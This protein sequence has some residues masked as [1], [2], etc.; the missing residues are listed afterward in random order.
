MLQRE[1]SSTDLDHALLTA[2]S[3]PQSRAADVFTESYAMRI[4]FESRQEKLAIEQMR[5]GSALDVFGWSTTRMFEGKYL[6]FVF[7]KT[8]RNRSALQVSMKTWEN[9]MHG[10]S[11]RSAAQAASQRWKVVQ[12][13]NDDTYFLSRDVN[14]PVTSEI[15]R[16]YYLRFRVRSLSGSGIAVVTQ[17]VHPHELD[18]ARSTEDVLMEDQTE[19]RVWGNEA[20]LWTHFVPSY[21]S[22][23]LSDGQVKEYEHCN[24][25]VVGKSSFGDERTAQLNA[26]ETVLGLLRWEN[27]NVGPLLTLTAA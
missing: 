13:V 2:F 20:C 4:I 8:F 16:M 5:L 27:V 9:E 19:R 6:Y 15:V 7:T 21:E 23:T 10:V 1:Q 12:Q 11:Y 24:V 18:A 25:K 3:A 17:S 22:V 26:L 14:D